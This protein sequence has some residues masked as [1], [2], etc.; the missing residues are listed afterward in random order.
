MADFFAS[1]R[2]KFDGLRARLNLPYPGKFDDMHLGAQSIFASRFLFDGLKVDLGTGHSAN[3]HTGHGM[4]LGSANM[5]QSYSYTALFATDH[6]MMQ[7]TVETDGSLMGRMLFHLAPALTSTVDLR[8][9]PGNMAAMQPPHE[10]LQAEMDYK[11]ADFAANFK[12][13]NPW[14]LDFTGVA[15]ASYLQSVTS[16]LALGI[17]TAV[18]NPAPGHADASLT[19]A[20]KYTLPVWHLDSVP[21]APGEPV[22]QQP[23]AAPVATASIA[24]HGLLHL[25]YVQPVSTKATVATEL[26]IGMSPRGGPEGVATVAAK[27]DFRDSTFRTQIDSQG[28]I[29]SV[30]EQR[31]GV[32]AFTMA[33]E[34]DHWKGQSRFGFGLQLEV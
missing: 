17:E 4:R 32:M 21:A 5:P 6:Q 11:G 14:P 16:R 24:S 22:P 8:Y 28:K 23:T 13:A 18:H 29:A 31:F 26:N 20:A 19:L 15:V 2:A 3:F 10:S 9:V 1:A 27:Y 25:A 33:G 7:G 12:L 34:V 30:L